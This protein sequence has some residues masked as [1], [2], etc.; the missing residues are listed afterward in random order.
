MVEG[1]GSAS[2]ASHRGDDNPGGGRRAPLRDSFRGAPDP[3]RIRRAIDLLEQA[4]A[5]PVTDAED[6]DVASRL[7]GARDLLSTSARR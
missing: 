2:F 6:F 1:L 7:T 5:K 3:T 4:L